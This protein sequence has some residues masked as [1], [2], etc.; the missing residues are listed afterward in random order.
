MKSA[1]TKAAEAHNAKETE[2]KTGQDEVAVG[3]KELR[4]GCAANKITPGTKKQ[5]GEGNNCSSEALASS[6]TASEATRVAAEL[7][8]KQERVAARNKE[9]CS[10]AVREEFLQTIES[11]PAH[12]IT[13]KTTKTQIGQHIVMEE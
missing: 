9:R 5:L 12:A 3:Q 4:H 8:S 10:A 1:A 13:K 6:A 11:P 2:H 7:K